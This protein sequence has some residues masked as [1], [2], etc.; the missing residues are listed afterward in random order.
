MAAAAS[1]PPALTAMIEA[2]GRTGARLA[3]TLPDGTTLASATGAPLARIVFSDERDVAALARGDHL[4]VAEAFLAARIDLEGDGFEVVKATDVLSLDVPWA[5]RALRLLR[6]RLPNRLAYNAAAI[7][8]H[9]DRPAEF[10]LPWFERWRSYSHGYYAA[11]DDDPSAAQGRKMQHAIDRLGLRPGMRVFDMGGGW[12]A[13]VEYAGLRGIRVE[14]I[15]ISR[16]QHR[17]VSDLIV[18]LGLPCRVELA[19]FLEYRPSAPYDAAVFMGTLEHVPDYRRVGG[20]LARWLT[21]EGRVYADFCAR[22]RAHQFAA[23]ITKH[24]WPGPV[25]AVDLGRLIGVLTGAGFVI[26]EVTDDTLS[27]AYTV[28]DWARGIE[29]HRGELAARFGEASVRTFLLLFWSSYHFFRT[30]RTRAYHVV[31][32]RRPREVGAASC[33]DLS[34]GTSPSCASSSPTRT[35]PSGAPSW[36]CRRRRTIGDART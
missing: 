35:A 10:F 25:A 3:L 19:D 12:G 14:T 34:A 16:A 13:F 2:L 21:P 7:A 15:T 27:Y 4:A 22:G 24:V 23:F 5:T 1:I 33:D 18:R 31:A 8:F 11:P 28:R 9:Y 26:H 30:R 17:F 32:G 29:A 6:L 20:F 36:C